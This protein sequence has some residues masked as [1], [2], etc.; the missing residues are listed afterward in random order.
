M[1]NQEKTKTECKRCGKLHNREDLQ[2]SYDYHGITFRL[3]CYKCM[4]E[5]DEIGYDGEKYSKF[6]ECLEDDY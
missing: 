1:P 5:I 4:A 3:V 6:D 2:F